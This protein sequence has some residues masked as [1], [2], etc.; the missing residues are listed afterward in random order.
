MKIRRRNWI[1]YNSFM[2]CFITK[3]TLVWPTS[4]K[5]GLIGTTWAHYLIYK[6]CF[7]SKRRK[8]HVAMVWLLR[9]ILQ[10]NCTNINNKWL[11][12]LASSQY[13]TH[14]MGMYEYSNGG[15]PHTCYACSFRPRM[16]ISLPKT[17]YKM[18]QCGD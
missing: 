15:L 1:T 9:P 5:R 3:L 18:D 11:P 4:Y 17:R 16:V 14:R 10:T 8:M 7:A 13:C 2:G 6:M 12:H